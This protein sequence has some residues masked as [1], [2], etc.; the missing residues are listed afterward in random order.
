VSWLPADP[1]PPRDVLTLEQAAAWQERFVAVV[2]RH[3]RGD[4]G[5]LGAGDVGMDP[6]LGRSRGTDATERVL[7]EA[8][9][10]QACALVRGAGTGAVRL[11]LFAGLPAGGTVLVHD[12]PTY[13]TSRLTLDAMGATV[14]ACDFNRPDAIREAVATSRPD[15]VLVQH[16]RPRPAD[17]YELTDVIAEVRGAGG[18]GV[19]VVVDDNYAPLK[20]SPLGAEAGADL[21]AFSCFKLGG[22]EGVG[23]VMGGAAHV[24]RVRRFMLSGGSMVQG[25]EAIA[26]IQA[27]ARAPLPIAHQ[28]RVTLEI[29]ERLS[30]GEVPGIRTA[31]ATNTP[32]TVVMLE[33]ER[34]HAGAV[35]AAA[36]ELGAAIRPVGMESY[37]EVVPAFLRPSKSMIEERPGVEDYVLRISAMR[38]GADLVLDILRTA[39]RQASAGDAAA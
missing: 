11:A 12:A 23:C 15:A 37:H 13:L 32:E 17:R 3:F 4:P 35:R 30:A 36:A 5:L 24:E 26:V 34:P 14:V 7:A 27:L 9:G 6:V 20:L 16:M 31:F 39:A 25:P 21:S 8:F 38:A 28:A 33:L 29:A 19:V 2:T 1:A 22:P 10:A 18:P